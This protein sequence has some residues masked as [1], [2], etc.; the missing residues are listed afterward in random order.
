MKKYRVHSIVTISLFGE[1]EAETDDE[2]E[3]KA[4]ELDLPSLCYQCSRQEK[5]SWRM[6]EV[7]GEPCEVTVEEK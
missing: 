1:V 3:E 7:D 4:Y 6:S 2:A 5:G